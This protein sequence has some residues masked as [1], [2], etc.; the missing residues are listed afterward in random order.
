MRSNFAYSYVCFLDTVSFSSC[1]VVNFTL[2][3][4]LHSQE[5][6]TPH[7]LL[8]EPWLQVSTSLPPGLRLMP[9]C[10]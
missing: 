5:P 1:F 8:D 9:P 6:V 10:V 7:D 2:H 4:Q 3:L